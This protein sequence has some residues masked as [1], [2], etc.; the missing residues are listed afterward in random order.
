MQQHRLSHSLPVRRWNQ[1]GDPSVERISK[2]GEVHRGGIEWPVPSE[3][4][5]SILLVKPGA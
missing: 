3:Q 5:A 4:L 2:C 1:I